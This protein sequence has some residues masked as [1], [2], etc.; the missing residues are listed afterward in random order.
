MLNRG[1]NSFPESDVKEKYFSAI[2]DIRK[3]DFNSA[4]SEFIEIIRT[5][6]NYDEDGA[7]KACIAIFKFLG[8]YHEITLNHRQDFGR[9][10][11]V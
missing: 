8:E 7:R 2:L 9:A 1:K 4:L 11:Y 3:Q 5:A 6:G 10:L